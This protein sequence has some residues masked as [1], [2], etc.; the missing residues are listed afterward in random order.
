[1]RS[2]IDLFEFGIFCCSDNSQRTGVCLLWKCRL[3][4]Q[5]FMG[6]YSQH[7]LAGDFARF[8]IVQL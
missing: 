5:L 4:W 3:M 6:E 2:S 7:S 8:P 1:M